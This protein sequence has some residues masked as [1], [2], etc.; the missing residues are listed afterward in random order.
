MAATLIQ[1]NSGSVTVFIQDTAGAPA[2]G[3]VDTDVTADLKKEGAASFVAY[4]LSP[5]NWLELG[6]GFYAIALTATET[7]TIGN[8]Y[9]RAQGGTIKT[10]L[11][12]AYVAESA[13]VNPPVVT[14][15]TSTPIFGYVYK[16]DSTPLVGATVS[17]RILGSPTVLH[18]GTDG[19]VVGQETV[20]VR[21]DS[22]GFFSIN[23]IAGTNVDFL[24]SA[25]NYRRTFLV[26]SVA[27]NV[28]DIP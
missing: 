4:V 19:L 10:T 6:D 18:P 28:F 16:T 15:P 2:V 5:L 8:L 3:L 27:T 17:A 26:P 7:D 22:S 23:L 1:S 21:T 12:V 20:V 9:L 13:P 14:P 24:I 25:A 11:T